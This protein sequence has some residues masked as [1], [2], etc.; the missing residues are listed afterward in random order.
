[1]HGHPA[2]GCLHSLPLDSSLL[3]PL[4]DM[5]CF[6]GRLSQNTSLMFETL[7]GA[8]PGTTSSK[9][10]SGSNPELS[11]PLSLRAKES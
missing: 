4:S 11:L 8:L 3:G 5:P 7:A 1:M 9:K 10:S 2:A 6:T